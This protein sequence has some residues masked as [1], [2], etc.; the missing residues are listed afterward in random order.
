MPEAKATPHP[1]ATLILIRDGTRGAEILLVRRAAALSFHGGAW[2]FPGGRIEDED[3]LAAGVSAD[4]RDAARH[5]AV[6]EAQEEAGVAIDGNS[7]ILLSRWITPDAMPRRFDTWFFAAPA[8]DE[9]VRVDG[10]EIDDHCWMPAEEALAAQSRSEIELPPP[11]FVTLSQ[12]TGRR[13]LDDAMNALR[14]R[15]F[16]CYEP[17]LVLVTGGAC[18]LYAGDAGYDSGDADRPGPRHRL[19]MLE[20]GWRYDCS[21]LE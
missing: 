20:S 1:A 16:V 19:W 13:S 4:V 6:R 18:T 17:R 7:L 15:P 12:L 3:R 11:T 14:Q 10:G 2:V 5:A 21:A 8:R 9:A